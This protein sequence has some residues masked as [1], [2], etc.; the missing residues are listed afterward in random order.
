LPTLLVHPSNNYGPFQFPEKLFPMAILNAAEDKPLPI[1]GDGQQT[2]DWLFGEDLCRAVALVLEK[3]VPGESFNVA[4]CV[5]CANE[6]LVRRI[7]ELV[8]Q[9]Q[10][11]R[12]AQPSADR[13]THVADRP[14]HDRRYA[15][16]TSRIRA[17]GWE[18][19]VR[20]DAGLEQTVHWYLENREWVSA[21]TAKFDRTRRLGTGK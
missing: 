12:A 14:G 13:I 3:G 8:D 9:S 5:E 19:R 6:K 10:P 18:P 11:Q 2:R 20:L 17:I 15:L 4:R 21:A 7:C 16:D 1:Y